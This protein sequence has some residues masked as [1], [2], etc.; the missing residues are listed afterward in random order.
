MVM[1]LVLFV[2][3][4]AG[5]ALAEAAATATDLEERLDAYLAAYEADGHLSGTLLVADRE[6]I[7]YER[8]FGMANHELGVSNGP[9]IRYCVASI[10][11][12]MTLVVLA[13]LLEEEK[14]AP[15]DLLTK[16]LPGFPRGETI[17][18]ERLARHEAG[19]P[20]RLL[21]ESAQV[22]P[23]T[24]A[25]MAELAAAA[26]LI[27][28]PGSSSSYSSGG[29]SVLARVLELAGGLSYQELLEKY[30]L[31]PAGMTD[32]A[33]ADAIALLPC[34]ASSYYLR[35]DGGLSNAPP[36]DLS[37]LVGAGSVFSTAR[38]LLAMMRALLDGRLGETAAEVLIRDDGLRWNGVTHGFRAFA[39]YHADTGTFVVFTSNFQTGAGDRI[40]RDVPKIAV[41]ET[42][43]TPQSLEIETVE[44]DPSILER[45]TGGFELRPGSVI[46]LRVVDGTLRANDWLLLPLSQ[47]EFFSPQDYARIKVVVDDAGEVERLD[48]EID[49]TVYP[50]PRVATEPGP[51]SERR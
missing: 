16:W 50:L 22:A 20:H 44:V 43:E 5:P 29:F 18:V 30:L 13:R 17:T 45:Y 12:P 25:D 21:D 2:L 47:T 11:K 34:R 28:E 36:R 3:L 35:A 24:A 7:R 40:R 48:W 19:I 37:F 51:A 15:D 8:S 39:D 49:G 42:V 32:T 23:M 33:H 14:V 31:E 4:A 6:Q 46:E 1:K 41:G 26:T 27:F 38:D 9:E 10:T